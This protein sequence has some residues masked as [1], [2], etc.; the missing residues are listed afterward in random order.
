[1]P[2]AHFIIF[3]TNNEYERAFTAADGTKLYDRL[4]LR[5]DG[6]H[7]EGLWVP[8]WFMNSSDYVAFFRPGEG[9]QAPLL[10]KAISS[11]RAQSQQKSELLNVFS[12]IE[13]T[14]NSIQALASETGK[15]AYYGKE[16]LRKSIDSLT[17]VLSRKE[18]LFVGRSES[19]T[20]YQN[21]LQGIRLVAVGSGAL[22]AEAND[23]I[24]TQLAS[25]RDQLSHD[26]NSLQLQ[27]DIP[28]GVD[29]PVH[30]DFNEF[31][32]TIFQEELARESQRDQ[33]LRSYV[34]TLQLRLEQARQDPRYAFLF[35]PQPFQQALASFLRLLIGVDPARNFVDSEPPWRPA[36]EEQYP[37]TTPTHQITILDLSQLASEVL[38]NVTALIGRLLLEFMQR[39]P[40][41]QRGKF[42]IVLVLEEA[43]HYVPDRVST[44]RQQRARDV[45][46]KI[47]KEGRKFGLSL[48][49]ASQRPSELSR[50]VLAQCNSFIVHRIQNPDDQ[51]YFKSVISGI[52]RELLDQ[53]PALAQQQAIVMGDC[54][55]L[56]LQVRI[57]D[58]DP[59][60]RSN[61]PKFVKE[62]SSPNP[63]IPDFER[64]ARRWEGHADDPE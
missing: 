7:P 17:T 16:N 47:A 50:T 35:R 4:V 39:L 34:G 56:P 25:M 21:T 22:L 31:V 14:A 59:K 20:S 46:E 10:F 28:V 33:R 2:N 36:Y 15:G 62:W 60:P 9:A 12:I 49:V 23:T 40:S 30:F 3:D 24:R 43:H 61:D 63:T 64:I 26:R 48:L 45:F 37:S 27:E 57:N 44:E 6:D 51:Q 5:N 55:T 11:A 53:L 42:P 38:E 1:M 41:D 58:V 32:S 29:S 19:L 52:N 13:D 18:A 8:H 54:V